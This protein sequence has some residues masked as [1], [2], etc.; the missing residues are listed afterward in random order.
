MFD[1]ITVLGYAR[2]RLIS[3]TRRAGNGILRGAAFLGRARQLQMFAAEVGGG[4]LV[5]VGIS[6]WSIPG[7]LIVGGL[8]VMGAVEVRS[9]PAHR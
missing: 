3:S 8:A 4:V 1:P 5:L 2:N 7:A 6:Q 9:S